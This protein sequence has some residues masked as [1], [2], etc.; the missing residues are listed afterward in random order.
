MLVKLLTMCTVLLMSSAALAEGHDKDH[1]WDFRPNFAER[2]AWERRADFLRHQVLVAQGLW[3]MPAKPPLHP[4]I[5]GRIERD[6]YTIEKVF[7]A[8]LPGHYVSG[9]LYRPKNRSGKLPAVLC[10]YGHWPDGRFIW[11]SDEDVKKELDSGAETDANAARSP[12]QANCAAL[13]R[14]GCIVFHYDMVGYADSTKIEHRTGFLDAEAALRCQSFMGLQTWNSIRALDFVVGLPEV[15]STRVAVTGSSGGG[16]QTF[17]LSA[18]DPRVTAAFPM[19]MVSMNMQG[20]CVCENAPLL[21][22]R[23]NNVELASLFAPRPMGMVAANDWT[24]DFLSRG[25]PEMKSIWRLYRA[26]DHVAAEHFDYGH[27]HNLHSRLAQYRFLNRHLRLGL[28]EPLDEKPFDPIPPTQLEVYDDAHPL[29]ADAIDAAGV[30]EWMTRASDEAI[31][32]I[33]KEPAEH[34]QMLT[35]AL[36]AMVVA[37]PASPTEN[38]TFRVSMP[39]KFNGNVVVCPQAPREVGA[40]VDAGSAVIFVDFRP[41]PKPQ[42]S[43][44]PVPHGS[45]AGFTHGYNRGPL[46][47]QVH[48]LLNA[49]AFAR[50]VEGA[51]TVGLLGIGGAGPASLLACALAAD[52]LDR[53]VIDLNQFDF[54]HVRDTDD[55]MFLPGALKYGGMTSFAR[56]CDERRTKIFNAKQRSHDAAA[57]IAEMLE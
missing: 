22:I 4:V 12:L 23:T 2:G 28:T 43:P 53:A 10:P 9:N 16:T 6:D 29:P 49:I 13:A 52:K 56:L 25:L 50:R 48:D 30:R 27:N 35:T 26:E 20:G 34:R 32:K 8:S 55:P 54:Q 51:K 33:A 15:D 19:V 17:I 3:P 46:A 42:E 45:Y 57:L 47:Q 21:R 37:D 40:L 41:P 24:H 1:P 18:V 36:A 31:A 44:N 5:H 38:G 7:F 39:K 11:K 14:S